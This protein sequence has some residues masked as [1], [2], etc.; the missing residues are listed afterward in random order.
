VPVLGAIF[1]KL[2]LG[3]DARHSFSS[4]EKYVSAYFRKELPLH[5]IYAFLPELDELVKQTSS[6]MCAGC[7]RTDSNEL[8]ATLA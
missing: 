4:C 7:G 3:S 5:H 6:G 8:Q 1:N 2:S